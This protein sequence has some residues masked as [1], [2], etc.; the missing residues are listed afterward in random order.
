MGFFSEKVNFMLLN[1]LRIPLA[2]G[3]LFGLAVMPAR[4][5]TISTFGDNDDWSAA[6]SSLP[7][8]IDLSTHVGEN[9][10]DSGGLTYA[11]VQFIGT[12]NGSGYNIAVSNQSDWGAA[13]LVE[14]G[15]T[16]S[17]VS[18]IQV[19]LPSNTTAAAT[20]VMM[21]NDSAGY[22]SVPGTVTICVSLDGANCSDFTV[23]ASGSAPS[24]GNAGFF[25]VTATSNIQW[26]DFIAP[27][28]GDQVLLNDFEYFD[29]DDTAPEP[30][31]ALLMG[32]GLLLLGGRM[33]R[34]RA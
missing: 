14:P 31:S 25:G 22:T 9:S 12:Y 28:A 20:D 3:F 17:N 19:V 1:K 4:A 16:G 30:W 26:I 5:S 11:G 24:P 7:T 23:T 29:E 27:S 33:V 34:H 18:Y 6:L 15:S 13:Y 21:Q 32:S 2:V 10:Q 8:T